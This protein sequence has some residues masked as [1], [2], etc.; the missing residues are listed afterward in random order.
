M[1]LSGS[2][3][4]GQCSF[5]VVTDFSTGYKSLGSTYV[6]LESIIKIIFVL[7]NF[8]FFLL[9]LLDYIDFMNACLLLTLNVTVPRVIWRQYEV[10]DQDMLVQMVGQ[11]KRVLTSGGLGGFDESI[12]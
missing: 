9:V 8:K 12:G 10:C 11:S 7:Y 4:K 5:F 2:L 6:P 3:V 1:K